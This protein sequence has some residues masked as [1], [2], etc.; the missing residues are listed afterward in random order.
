VSWIFYAELRSHEKLEPRR[1]VFSAAELR[2]RRPVYALSDCRIAA[3]EFLSFDSHLAVAW[4]KM[5]G[6]QNYSDLWTDPV[7]LQALQTTLIFVAVTV[8]PSCYSALAWHW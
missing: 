6:W 1:A 4:S 2:V 7:A 3:L 5:V 8:R